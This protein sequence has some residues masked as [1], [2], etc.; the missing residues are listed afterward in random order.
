VYKGSGISVHSAASMTLGN[1]WQSVVEKNLM[2]IATDE[3]NYYWP[4]DTLFHYYLLMETLQENLYE[5]YE[6]L[7]MLNEAVM[8]FNDT[9]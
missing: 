2:N 9:T 3:A 5:R 7:H 6:L 4:A 8:A 1:D